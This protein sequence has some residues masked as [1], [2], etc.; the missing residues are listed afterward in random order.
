V[1]KISGMP[2]F[3]SAPSR[4]FRG[5]F[6]VLEGSQPRPLQHFRSTVTLRPNELKKSEGEFGPPPAARS[7]KS[8]AFRHRQAASKSQC[9]LRNPSAIDLDA[10]SKG[11]RRRLGARPEHDID[12]ASIF[13]GFWAQSFPRSPFPGPRQRAPSP[14]FFPLCFWAGIGTRGLGVL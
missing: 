5:K 2:P 14:G 4:S 7:Y 11:N 13:R 3:S 6:P 8:P 1:E 12:V 9:L 10:V